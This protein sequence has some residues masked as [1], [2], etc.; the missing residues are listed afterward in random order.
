MFSLFS[1]FLAQVLPDLP[2]SVPATANAAETV[3]QAAPTAPTQLDLLQIFE[4]GG[5]VMYPLLAISLI[6]VFIIFYGLITVRRNNIV[7]DKFMTNAEGFLRKGDTIGLLDYS[8]RTEQSISYITEKTI[9]FMNAVPTASIEEIR[10]V[11]EA[12]GSRQAGM[13][14]RRVALLAD[15]GTV[16]PMLGLLG[17][18]FGMIKA[19]GEIAGGFEGAR[20]NA[21]ADSV[22]EAL[23]TTAA[24]LVV[25]IPSIIAYALL[26]GRVQRCLSELEA[27]ATHIMALLSSHFKRTTSSTARTPSLEPS[28]GFADFSSKIP[29][30][31]GI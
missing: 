12:E 25:G 27:A 8:Q 7:S 10:E 15:I 31:H 13:L 17:T 1:T 30:I 26:R 20:Q 29:D 22:S 18:V 3:T 23:I 2:A 6:A 9:D 19:F 11:A 24:G 14:N 5:F 4:K 21:L 16:A 28:E